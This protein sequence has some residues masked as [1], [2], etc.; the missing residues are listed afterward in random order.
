MM[1]KIIV[2]LAAALLLAPVTPTFADDAVAEKPKRK[3]NM[4]TYFNQMDIAK[5][6]ATKFETPILV[7]VMLD[8]DEKSTMVKRYVLNN[9]FFKKFAPAN[10]VTLVLK[11][12]KNEKDKKLV[13]KK[14]FKKGWDLIEKFGMDADRKAVTDTA[15]MAT[16]YP[17]AFFVS[18]DCEKKLA[19]LPK[20]DPELGFGA[21]AMEVVAKLEAAGVSAVVSPDLK[22]AIENPQ[23]DV[24]QAVKAGKKK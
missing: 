7:I 3:L 18:A 14:S 10:F 15:D 12:K 13:D 4:K 21:W 11:G 8:D 9:K 6:D 23:P 17:T 5:K 19:H 24:K 16:K 2:T 20:Y 1:K 22:K